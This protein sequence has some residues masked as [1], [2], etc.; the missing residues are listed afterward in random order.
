MGEAQGNDG[1]G[2][3]ERVGTGRR[4]LQQ[5]AG[6]IAGICRLISLYGE[7]GSDI[8]HVVETAA[9]G[10]IGIDADGRAVLRE[11]DGSTGK[12]SGTI[13]RQLGII[14]PTDEAACVL[15]EHADL[16]AIGNLCLLQVGGST[17][18]RGDVADE[19]QCG[20]LV[21]R[22]GVHALVGRAGCHGESH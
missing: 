7:V 3:R 12:G 1:V 2:L 18:T 19:C 6:Q 21:A 11:I 22:G 9:I 4:A 15:D 8:G 13:G 5:V 16:N 20:T 17:A 14:T 10:G